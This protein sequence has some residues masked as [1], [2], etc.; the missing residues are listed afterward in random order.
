MI[1]FDHAATGLP[2]LPAALTAL[3]HAA[4]LGSAGRGHHRVAAEANAALTGAREAVAAL[5]GGGVVCFTSGATAALNQA[6]LGLRPAPRAVAIDPLLHDAAR[7]PVDALAVPTW[8]LPHDAA[9]I[10]RAHV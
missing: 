3:A 2:R 5:T 10:G 7:R 9:E 4:T 6:I 1:Y 8:T